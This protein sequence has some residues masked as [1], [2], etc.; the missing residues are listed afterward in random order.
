MI[1]LVDTHEVI[2]FHHDANFKISSVVFSLSEFTRIAML[3]SP[4]SPFLVVE[5]SDTARRIWRTRR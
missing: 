5:D 4:G 3:T 2:C 1:C